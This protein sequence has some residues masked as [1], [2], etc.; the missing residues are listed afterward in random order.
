MESVIN[1]AGPAEDRIYESEERS[2]EIFRSEEN[3]GKNVCDLCGLPNQGRPQR[4]KAT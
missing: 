2:A 4:R 1:R 3:K